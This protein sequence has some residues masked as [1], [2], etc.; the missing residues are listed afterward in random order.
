M[1][2]HI[3]DIRLRAIAL[4]RKGLHA[5][6]LEGFDD[7]I[8]TLREQF[9]RGERI[10]AR[11][12]AA[13][14][15][16]RA[17]ALQKL[18]RPEETLI[19]NEEILEILASVEAD[20]HLLSS[21]ADAML[22]RAVALHQLE[23]FPEEVAQFDAL[24]S[25]VRRL[26]GLGDREATRTLAGILMDWAMLLPAEHRDEMIAGYSEATYIL[27][28]LVHSGQ[29]ELLN[30]LA[31][32]LQEHSRYMRLDG[33]LEKALRDLDRAIAIMRPRLA[34]TE[35]DGAGQLARALMARSVALQAMERPADAVKASNEAVRVMRSL[36]DTG[37]DDELY[38][39]SHDLVLRTI[40]VHWS[41]RYELAIDFFDEAIPILR[42]LVALDLYLRPRCWRTVQW[43]WKRLGAR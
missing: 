12:L 32:S 21:Q 1:D 3:E 27:E 30:D 11:P 38:G 40:E 16:D 29:D 13:V 5:E 24:I 26:V 9:K 28:D 18:E 39:M 23:R 8:A 43:R 22:G 31:I 14:L 41:E 36:V 37:L 42:E 35:E 33:Q 20:G 19:A 2:H 4:G 34:D 7:V 17:L 25:V 6:A 15:A 10:V